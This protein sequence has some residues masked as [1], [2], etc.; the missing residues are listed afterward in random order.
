MLYSESVSRSVEINALITKQSLHT[1]M[2]AEQIT[3]SRYGYGDTL[4]VWA[5]LHN[6]IAIKTAFRRALFVNAE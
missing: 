1:H 5:R 2:I 6:K 3:I 4:Q